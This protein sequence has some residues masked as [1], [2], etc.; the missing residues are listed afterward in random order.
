MPLASFIES[1]ERSVVRGGG[2]AVEAGKASLSYDPSKGS[3]FVLGR[4]IS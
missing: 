3:A 4:W 2:R 1:Y